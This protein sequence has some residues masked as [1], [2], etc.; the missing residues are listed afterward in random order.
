[1]H[2]G[3]E[4]AVMKALGVKSLVQETDKG[5]KRLSRIQPSSDG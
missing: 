5:L 3:G 4:A 1:M 2:A